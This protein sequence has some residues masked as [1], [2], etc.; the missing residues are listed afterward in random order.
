[1]IT[2][3]AS[4]DVSLTPPSAAAQVAYAPLPDWVKYQPWPEEIEDPQGA[5]TDNGLMR[6]LHD[7]QVSLLHAGSACHVHA[8]Q[9]VLTRNGAE[10]AAQLIVEFDPTYERVEVHHFRVWRAGSYIEHAQSS[11]DA[12]HL[13][14]R[15]KQLER[16]ALNGRLSATLL[17]PDVRVDDRVEFAITQYSNNPV[18]S[19]RYMAWIV[20]N[21]YGPWVETRQRLLRPTARALHFKAFNEPPP[22][23]RETAGEV[24]ESRWSLA[25]QERRLLEDLIPPWTIK[26]PSYQVS[27]Y[28]HWSE[29]AKLFEPYYR[30]NVLPEDLVRQLEDLKSK[31][32]SDADRAVEWL[33]FVQ[34]HIRYFAL[35]LG[36]GGLVPRP[37][38]TI[39][40]GRFGDCKD[41]A[42]LFVAGAHHLGLD[43]SAALVSTTHGPSL[44]A[45]LPSTQAFNHMVVRLRL[46]GATYWLDP[47]SQ[48]QGGSLGNID[49]PHAGWALPVTSDTELE[50]LPSA[51]SVEHIR[52]DD[53]IELGPKP[54]SCA[55][56]RR[57]IEL[58]SWSANNVRHRMQNEGGS[59]LS[60][61][62][63]Q[64]L[65][66][67][68]PGIV[69]TSSVIVEDDF[70]ANRLTLRFTYEIAECWKREPGKSR[71]EFNIAD[72]FT[73][74][75][76]APPKNTRR[77]SEIFLG[78]PRTV[79]WRARI[80]MPRRWG[81]RGWLNVSG[82]RGAILRND[83]TIDSRT[84]ILERVLVIDQWVLPADRADVYARLVL[85]LSRNGAKLYARTVFGRIFSVAGVLSTR[86]LWVIAVVAWW[87]LVFVLPSM[88]SSPAGR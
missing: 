33:R 72:H 53:E 20:F 66:G 77:N 46:G 26:S 63:L 30:E 16:L 9:R 59:K 76:L 54:G 29:V 12:L 73:S 75:E 50:A 22:A 58:R 14:R 43:A 24:E 35:S 1:M 67:V 3:I 40:A 69:E 8:V 65:H 39:W 68:W 82:E 49:F 23:V 15:E 74:K 36:E 38:G 11:T 45:F 6:L 7:T 51:Q 10:R 62:L 52:C 55:V 70:S 86:S 4:P 21:S 56:L 80:Q 60:E 27:E 88:C 47:T 87:L 42:R 83:L 61:Q 57:R 13:L 25:K 5:W 37:L 17:I 34:R 19:G 28:E 71:W 41:A 18:V 2:T 32:P 81:G 31:Y 78:R 79:R 44:A 85:D 64:A 48:A 84:L